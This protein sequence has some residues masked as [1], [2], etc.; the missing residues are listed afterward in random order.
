MKCNCE[1]LVIDS[2]FF[3]DENFV[4]TSQS[5]NMRMIMSA[6]FI[7]K[8]ILFANF[9]FFDVYLDILLFID[10]TFDF[11]SIVCF[12]KFVI[13]MFFIIIAKQSRHVYI[14]LLIFALWSCVL[15]IVFMIIL[16]TLNHSSITFWCFVFSSLL[17][18]LRF[19]K[20]DIDF[21]N[22]Y[23]SKFLLLMLNFF[24]IDII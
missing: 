6:F 9:F 12:M 18:D 10:L 14:N 2:I 13:L 5:L 22:R 4:L 16:E 20:N 24:K 15:T 11:N 23:D 19:V 17:C 21:L 8:K 1:R 3:F 7:S